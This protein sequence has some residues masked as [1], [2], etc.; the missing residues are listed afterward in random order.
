MSDSFDIMPFAFT[1]TRSLVFANGQ[2]EDPTD[3]IALI[4][5]AAE[6]ALEK[7]REDGKTESDSFARRHSLASRFLTGLAWL[8]VSMSEDTCAADFLIDWEQRAGMPIGI[9]PEPGFWGRFQVQWQGISIE[10]KYTPNKY[11][12]PGHDHVEI[13][14]PKTLPI[15]KTGYKSI[16]LDRWDLFGFESVGAWV[17]AMLDAESTR[18]KQWRLPET[19]PPLGFKKPQQS[20]ATP[21]NQ[22]NLF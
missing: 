20:Q 7:M 9:D 3:A 4:D 5:A 13:K 21:E 11:I 15:T 6:R 1:D 22:L 8:C 14:S 12:G 2:P 10:V 16:H 18:N 17:V 19:I